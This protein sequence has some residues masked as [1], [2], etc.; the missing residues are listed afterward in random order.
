[1]PPP[2]VFGCRFLGG[3]SLADYPQSQSVLPPMRARYQCRDDQSVNR[4]LSS[5][6]VRH[7]ADAR[8]PL[9]GIPW[10]W[11]VALVVAG[12][13]ADLV[14]FGVL[15]LPLVLYVV[16]YGAVAT[17]LLAVWLVARRQRWAYLAAAAPSRGNRWNGRHALR[18]RRP[19]TREP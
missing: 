16:I 3:R 19:Q 7:A 1:M 5:T 8:P 10:R 15:E 2:R 12:L 17:V 14:F 18:A 9:G 13:L 6:G 11:V 4:P